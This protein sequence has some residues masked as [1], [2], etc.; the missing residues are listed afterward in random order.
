MRKRL[1]LFA[2]FRKDHGGGVVPMLAIAIVPMM[3]GVGAAVDFSRINAT[4]TAFQSA[5]DSTALMLAK[6]ARDLSGAQLTQKTNDYFKALFGP[7]PGLQYHPGAAAH[8]AGAGHVPA[9]Y[10]RQCHYEY[11]LRLD[12]GLFGGNVFSQFD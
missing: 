1:S 6:E 12:H 4:R 9:Q 5:I 8:L 3:A 2:R 11:H 10:L 7:T